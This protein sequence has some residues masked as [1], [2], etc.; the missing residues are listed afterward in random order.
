MSRLKKL[1]ASEGDPRSQKMMTDLQGKG[2]LLNIFRGMA[3]SPAVLEA[4]LKFSSA[5]AGGLLDGRTREAVALAVGQVNRCEYCV[6]AHT[7]MG[8]GAGLSEQEMLEA[9]VGKSADPKMDAAIKLAINLVHNHGVLR[10]ADVDAV[11]QAGLNDG[12]IAEVIGGVALNVF[13]NYFN[14][15]NQTELDLPAVPMDVE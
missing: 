11:R 8:K 1:Q 10:E 13:T 6:S 15:V 12:E 7:L 4:Y 9:R 14:H 2:K 3:N 5:L